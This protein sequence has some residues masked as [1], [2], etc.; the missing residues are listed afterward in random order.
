MSKQQRYGFS[1]ANLEN[2]AKAQ[3]MILRYQKFEKSHLIPKT[4]E[5][6]FYISTQELGK[7]VDELKRTNADGLK[8]TNS[9]RV[10]KLGN[11]I[12]EKS[13]QL[14]ITPIVFQS[15]NSLEHTNVSDD[16]YWTEDHGP[17]EPPIINIPTSGGHT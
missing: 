16:F 17:I 13:M 5:Q 9:I 10:S 1:K 7:I 4:P 3:E 15:E 11:K 12:T 14:I 8:I 6:S 2:Q